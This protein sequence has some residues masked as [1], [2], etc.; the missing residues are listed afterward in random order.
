MMPALALHSPDRVKKE[1][2][3]DQGHGAKI[4]EQLFQIRPALFAQLHNIL[5]ENP[6]SH[7]SKDQEEIQGQFVQ[8]PFLLQVLS[9]S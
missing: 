1:N 4:Y 8:E 7:A 5:E 3:G 9:H 2:Q 6:G